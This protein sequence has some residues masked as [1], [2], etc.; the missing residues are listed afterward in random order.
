[1]N[2]YRIKEVKLGDDW[3]WTPQF[4]PCGA[5]HKWSQCLN[6]D[7]SR[8][9]KDTGQSARHWLFWEEGS[10][11]YEDAGKRG[12]VFIYD[13]DGDKIEESQL[14][15]ESDELAEQVSQA[16]IADG[17][18]KYELFICNCGDVNHQ[19][20][21]TADDKYGEVEV[22]V[23]VRLNRN[24]PWY[25][26]LVKGLTYIFGIGKPSIFGDYDE[27]ILDKSHIEG[28]QKVIEVLKQKE[29]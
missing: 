29:D 16:N 1:M 6:D 8:I 22:F 19:F 12:K 17:K 14:G 27:I 4:R 26:R 23:E 28:L 9:Y 24:L 3:K 5:K 15:Q 20:V 21:V 13:R 18:P 7:G 25:K 2:E 11:L 10:H